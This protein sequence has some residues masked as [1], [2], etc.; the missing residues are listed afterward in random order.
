[1]N[2]LLYA[3]VTNDQVLADVNEVGKQLERLLN[4]NWRAQVLYGVE[5]KCPSGRVYLVDNAGLNPNAFPN[6]FFPSRGPSLWERMSQDES[7]AAR[8]VRRVEEAINAQPLESR[9]DFL[10][11]RR[12]REI[13][14]SPGGGANNSVVQVYAQARVALNAVAAADPMLAEVSG[15]ND[16][17][18]I[19][20]NF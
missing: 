3:S 1:M 5:F 9:N 20:R 8:A 14:Q 4:N 16:I 2:S 11:F 12:L 10:D 18:Q 17:V 19:A 13:Q 7:A 6:H 15:R